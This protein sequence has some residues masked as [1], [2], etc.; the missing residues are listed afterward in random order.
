MQESFIGHTPQYF[1]EFVPKI[2]QLSNMEI[3]SEH[4]I[5]KLSNVTNQMI[6]KCLKQLFHAFG[7]CVLI[8]NKKQKKAR[9]AKK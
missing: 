8:G 1:S 3:W 7:R 5:S 2:L 6:S 4:R 9:F